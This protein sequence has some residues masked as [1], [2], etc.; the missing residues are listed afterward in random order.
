MSGYAEPVSTGIM[1]LADPAVCTTHTLLLLGSTI[2]K[3]GC[4]VRQLQAASQHQV[5]MPM[6]AQGEDTVFYAHRLQNQQTTV[7][8]DSPTT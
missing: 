3:T 6:A 4:G 2:N 1:T 7:S 8:E 5:S